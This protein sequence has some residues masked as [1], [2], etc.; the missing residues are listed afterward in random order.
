[1][2]NLNETLKKRVVYA[3]PGMEQC[4]VVQDQVYKTVDERDLM[5]DAYY[6]ADIRDG[7]RRPVVIF[8]HGLGPDELVR[9][10]KDSGQ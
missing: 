8:V 9:H 4:K 2:A 5:L 3:I 10:S 6:P 7:E 1:M